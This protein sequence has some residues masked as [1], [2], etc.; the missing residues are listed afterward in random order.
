MIEIRYLDFIIIKISLLKLTD[1]DHH[2]TADWENC[3]SIL[4]ENSHVVDW[5]KP[6]HIVLLLQVLEELRIPSEDN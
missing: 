3:D 1:Y 5:A 6:V 2:N 4:K